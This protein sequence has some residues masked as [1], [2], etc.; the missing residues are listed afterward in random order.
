MTSLRTLTALL[1]TGLT[2]D[3][4]EAKKKKKS[5]NMEKFSESERIKHMDDKARRNL[6]EHV[7]FISVLLFLH[8]FVISRLIER[9]RERRE[10]SPGPMAY[11]IF[12]HAERS[13]LTISLLK[14][15]I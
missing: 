6:Q 8:Y 2:R 4:K 1:G 15:T 13:A 7:H 9:Y 3:K 14:F 11:Y 5:E 12:G 10:I